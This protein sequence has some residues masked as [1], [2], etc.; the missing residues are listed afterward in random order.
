MIKWSKYT[1][2]AKSQSFAADNT[3]QWDGRLK[4][5]ESIFSFFYFPAEGQL[6]FSTGWAFVFNVSAA[7]KQSEKC[8]PR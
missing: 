6:C 2:S 5:S 4:D 3:T 1:L 7:P 8:K